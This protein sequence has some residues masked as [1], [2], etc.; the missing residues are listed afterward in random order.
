[1][2]SPH[3][4]RC[5]APRLTTAAPSAT[6]PYGHTLPDCAWQPGRSMSRVASPQP[7]LAL[8]GALRP[9]VCTAL[10]GGPT[11]APHDR[12]R[13]GKYR[14]RSPC[15]VEREH[16]RLR[17]AGAWPAPAR[18]PRPA[19]G[20]TGASEREPSPARG[21]RGGVDCPGPRANAPV[22]RLPVLSGSKA[23]TAC[24]LPGL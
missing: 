1:M 10:E 15:A 4:P 20:A 11:V 5:T 7:H 14:G 9:R 19:A 12:R 3:P 8:A 2:L 21:G 16:R 22:S 13:Q 18:L 24:P 17:S 23:S 6:G